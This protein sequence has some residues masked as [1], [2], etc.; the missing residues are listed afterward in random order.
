MADKFP[1]TVNAF[2]N[3][4][5]GE[6]PTADK[7]N[8]LVAQTK[9]GFS[10]L[11]TAI[12]DIHSASWPYIADET[13]TVS[14]RL[15]MPFYRNVQTG[16]EVAGADTEGR[17]LDI[18]SLARLIGP[19]SNLNPI[20]LDD[21]N[22]I[23]EEVVSGTSLT[24]FQLRY[25]VSGT[26]SATNPSFVNDSASAVQFFKSSVADVAADGDYHVSEDGTVFSFKPIGT[27]L[28]AS[29]TTDPMT[30][31]GGPNH[32][33]A[34]FNVIPDPNQVNSSS[35]EKVVVS[36]AGA[37]GLHT[38][39]LPLVT[40]QQTNRLG[41][42]S[43]LDN[44]QDLNYQVQ[45]KLPFVLTENMTI[46]QTIP[47]GFLYLKNVTTNEVYTEATYIYNDEDTF[48]AGNIDLEDRIN[49]GDIF[50]VI[51][52]GTDIT[53]AILDLQYKLFNHK[54]GRAFGE[55]L[56]SVLELADNYRL[57]GQ[58]GTFMPSTMNGN[59][60]S[61]YLHRDGYRPNDESTICNDANAMRG[62]LVFSK[63]SGSPGEYVVGDNGV[64]NL[65]DTY[66]ISFGGNCGDS[67][68]TTAYGPAI[69]G[70]ANSATTDLV[71]ET[72]DNSNA[73]VKVRGDGGFTVSVSENV[74]IL[75]YGSDGIG[76]TA[77]SGNIDLQSG[78]EAILYAQE[79]ITITSVTDDV[80]I[81]AYDDI[82][83]TV[84]PSASGRSGSKIILDCPGWATIPEDGGTASYY[85]GVLI[86]DSDSD[87]G[88]ATYSNSLFQVRAPNNDGGI[89]YF[90]NTSSG[91][92]T[93]GRILQLAFSDR[94]STQCGNTFKNFID[95]QVSNRR[96]GRVESRPTAGVPND[97]FFC[98]D[99]SGG[100]ATG[101][102][103]SVQRNGDVAYISG[104][105]DFGELVP[106]GDIDEWK[107]E[108]KSVP[109]SNILGLS[110]GMVVFVREGKFWRNEPGTP[111]IVTNR[112]ILIGNSCDE[113]ESDPYEVL[114]FIGQVPVW[115][116]GSYKSGDY[117]VPIQENCC[118]AISP[119]GI[120]FDM[121]RRAVG[122]AWET[123]LG[124]VNAEEYHR[125][126]C[127]VGI[128]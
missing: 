121:Y 78:K 107:P 109:E 29:Y 110:E 44:S 64:T 92:S 23:V 128:K 54:H 25:P 104:S 56:V 127:A 6:Q 2:I 31:G 62:N 55:Q 91:S 27:N 9:Y 42:S 28:R 36:I 120:S 30:Y 4:V 61:Q 72:Q 123:C 5:A 103:R 65:A 126:L 49:A 1:S 108:I 59:H 52:V 14:T 115:V 114:S 33:Y 102:G 57:A 116:K 77:P 122:T 43:S 24:E 38:I 117:L 85:K 82:V 100:F 60:F 105:Q 76:L 73:K 22:Q 18:V 32:P 106:A 11:E 53:S 26:I 87:T 111:M 37:D 99:G 70:D 47:S 86:C 98:E 20:V 66:G 63:T 93:S 124:T 101:T 35:A 81:S 83:L 15:T 97:A 69:W 10:G 71:L 113:T 67:V 12:G 84:D 34:R 3:F 125:V 80:N 16:D 118:V 58:S 39:Q 40:H 119:D 48:Q 13:S 21:S 45:A 94:T 90:D 7:F 96:V 17:S 75:G 79:D 50:Q 88:T 95:F 89:V 74:E 51:T 19:S 46:G 8:A 41:N 112:A 68:P